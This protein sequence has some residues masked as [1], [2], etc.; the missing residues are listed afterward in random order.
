MSGAD[1][2]E[3][4]KVAMVPYDTMVTAFL[5]LVRDDTEW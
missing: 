1:T 2:A 5:V 4:L 3:V